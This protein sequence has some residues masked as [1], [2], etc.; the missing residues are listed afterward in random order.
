MGSEMCIRDRSNRVPFWKRFEAGNRATGVAP[1][2][3]FGLT[4][5]GVVAGL[6]KNDETK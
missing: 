2:G 1:L 3:A 4:S 5:V 6:R